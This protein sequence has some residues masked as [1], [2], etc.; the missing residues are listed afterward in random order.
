MNR[1]PEDMM[2]EQKQAKAGAPPDDLL[3]ELATQVRAQEARCADVNEAVGDLN[4]ALA[5]AAEAGLRAD[6]EVSE[7]ETYGGKG[8]PVVTCKVYRQLRGLRWNEAGE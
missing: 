1:R 4:G 8:R 6:L 3:A 5:N 2:S 7:T